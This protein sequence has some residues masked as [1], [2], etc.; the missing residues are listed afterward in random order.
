MDS[1]SGL[2]TPVVRSGQSLSFF[3]CKMRIVI[4]PISGYNGGHQIEQAVGT[5]SLG[6][7][8]PD[9]S[10]RGEFLCNESI[11]A[12]LQGNQGNGGRGWGGQAGWCG[13]GE[14]RSDDT[15]LALRVIA[16]RAVITWW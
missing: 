5:G 15:F 12:G 7:G 10:L 2:I 14:P 6:L 1:D 11:R 13:G 8:L 9:Q 3:V 16:C 4:L